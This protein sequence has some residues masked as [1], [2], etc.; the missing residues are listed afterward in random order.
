[1]NSLD[2]SGISGE[3]VF[4]GLGSLQ[5]TCV[6]P[7]T[8]RSLPVLLFSCLVSRSDFP[9]IVVVFVF[10]MG[11]AGSLAVSDYFGLSCIPLICIV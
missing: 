10:R 7:T 9:F 3:L 4:I 5:V 11:F 8:I 6:I 1:M 2:S